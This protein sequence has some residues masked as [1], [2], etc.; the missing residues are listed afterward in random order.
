MTTASHPLTAIDEVPLVAHAQR[1]GITV[2]FEQPVKWLPV[3]MYH[4]VVDRVIGPDPYHLRI[5]TSHFEAQMAYLRERGYQSIALHDVP[6]AICDKSPW[7]KP[8]AI[9]FDD[10]YLDTYTHAYPILKKYGMTA[11]IMLVSDFIGGQSVW[12]GNREQPAQLLSPDKIQ[13]ME[14]NGMH[15]GAHSAKHPSLP[16][17][18]VEEVRRELAGSKAKLET[19]LGHEVPTLAY[20]YGRSTAEVRQIAMDVGFAASFGVEH[21]NHTLHNFSRIDCASCRGNTLLWRLKVSGIYLRLRQN[22]MLRMLSNINKRIR[23]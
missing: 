12:D 23:T 1:G 6:A 17:V 3:L 9:S 20:P 15:F 18:G 2:R 11:T 19:L 8:V 21:W 5:Q 14:R 7:N 10:G 16:H 22:R 4:R 13:E